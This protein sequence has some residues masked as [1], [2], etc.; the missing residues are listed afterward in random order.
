MF[1]NLPLIQSVCCLLSNSHLSIS[2]FFVTSDIRRN[3]I[4]I[5]HSY[6]S[7][8]FNNANVIADLSFLLK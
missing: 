2:L 4:I 7:T 3:T 8:V 5:I 6:I 1:G